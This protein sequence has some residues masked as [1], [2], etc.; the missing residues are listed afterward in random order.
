MVGGWAGF[1]GAYVIGPR[2]GKFEGTVIYE[3][4]NQLYCAMGVLFLWFGWYGFNCG[5]TLGVSGLASRTAGRVAATTTIAA[6][7]GAVTAAIMGRFVYGKY[8]LLL[9]LNGILA[10]LVRCPL[11]CHQP[12]P[13]PPP[14][15]LPPPTHLPS[16]CRPT[17][18]LCVIE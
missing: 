10:G 17:L 12:L 8:D 6:G 1:V 15:S 3:P 13:S 16:W 4:H 11:L 7:S 14:H 5:S 18:S 9:C 2:T